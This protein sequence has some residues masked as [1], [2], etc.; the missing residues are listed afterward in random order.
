MCPELPID[1]CLEL[2]KGRAAMCSAMDS[3]FRA[4]LLTNAEAGEVIAKGSWGRMSV[5]REQY[6]RSAGVLRSVV[7]ISMNC[8]ASTLPPGSLRSVSA[9]EQAELVI[10][11]RMAAVV[12]S[13][14]SLT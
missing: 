1:M 12:E 2:V 5:T 10:S 14:L 4:T 11:L 9:T 7:V 3:A 13:G 8:S 6:E